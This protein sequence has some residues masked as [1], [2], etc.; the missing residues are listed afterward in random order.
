[1]IC[2]VPRFARDDMH[3]SARNEMARSLFCLSAFSHRR[4]V[5]SAARRSR[6]A[7]IRR[8]SARN[9]TTGRLRRSVFNDHYRFDKPPLTYWLQTVSYR[10]FG[11]NDFA[12]RFPSAVAAALV[13]VLLL[14]WGRRMADERVGWWAAIIF[15]LCLQT[16]H[17]REGSCGRHV[18]GVVCDGSALGGIGIAVWERKTNIQ[19]LTRTRLARHP[20]RGGGFFIWLSLLLFS[21]KGQSVGLRCLLS[22]A[23]ETF[24]AR[25][26]FA[27]T[28]RV[29][30]WD[31]SHAGN[32]LA[33]GNSCSHSHT[34]RILSRRHWASCH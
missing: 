24:P 25:H 34:W 27:E 33:L 20:G 10:A 31:R 17:A 1:M 6:R 13:A 26:E 29:C 14:A 9:A 2:E 23:S 19:R 28:V 30:S 11:E 12:A 7:A 22:L 5:E 21:P 15:T 16:F 8:S 3:V 32:R 18:A 4:H